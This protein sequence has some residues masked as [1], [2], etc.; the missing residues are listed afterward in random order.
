M[1]W[2]WAVLC[3]VHSGGL[4]SCIGGKQGATQAEKKTYRYFKAACH[5]IFSRSPFRNTSSDVSVHYQAVKRA[6]ELL[7]TPLAPILPSVL[8]WKLFSLCSRVSW[9]LIWV[10][11]ELA[12][13]ALLL[14]SAQCCS[15]CLLAHAH[16]WTCPGRWGCRSRGLG[17]KRQVNDVGVITLNLMLCL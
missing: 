15:P 12:A 8:M 11:P 13:Q 14:A 10:Q 17:P 5:P 4:S 3:N 9:D 16:M 1:V 6:A 2:L 7:L